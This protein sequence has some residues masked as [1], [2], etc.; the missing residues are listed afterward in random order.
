MKTETDP[1]PNVIHNDIH[2]NTGPIFCGVVNQPVFM[3]PGA[4]YTPHITNNNTAADPPPRALSMATRMI[5]GLSI[6]QSAEITEATM[7]RR[8]SAL[9]PRRNRHSSFPFEV[10]VFV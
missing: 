5:W 4:N 8:K 10:L 2:G 1:A 6:S 3:Q 9:L 7:L